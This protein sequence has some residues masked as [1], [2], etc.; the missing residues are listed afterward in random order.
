MTVIGFVAIGIILLVWLA[1]GTI[2]VLESIA[3]EINNGCDSV[4]EA[5]KK[6]KASYDDKSWKVDADLAKIIKDFDPSSAD[7][8]AQIQLPN[9]YFNDSPDSIKNNLAYAIQLALKKRP[10]GKHDLVYSVEECERILPVATQKS[11]RLDWKFIQSSL[12]IPITYPSSPKILKYPQEPKRSGPSYRPLNIVVRLILMNSIKSS[13]KER[14]NKYE[15]DHKLWREVCQKIDEM[16]QFYGQKY[17]IKK[18]EWVRDVDNHEAQMR[19]HLTKLREGYESKDPQYVGMYAELTRLVHD[20]P[21][22]IPF[23]VQA[24]FNA[25]SSVLVADIRLPSIDDI[26][27]IKETRYI[28]SRNS[29]R[30]FKYSDKQLK[31]FYE[32][33]HYALMLENIYAIF[34]SDYKSHIESICLNGRVRQINKATGKWLDAHVLSVQTDRLEFSTID[35]KNVDAKAC[36]QK[37]KG[38]GSPHFAG[39]SAIQPII[40]L[41]KSDKR[42]VDSYNVVDGVADEENIA[43]MP[44]EDFENLIRELFEREFNNGGGEVKVTRASKDGGV[45]AVIFDPDPIRGGKIIIQAKRYTNSV[46]VSAVRDLYGT[47]IN[48]GANKGIM[49]TT[50][51]YG[52]DSYMFAKDKPITLLNGSNLM[53]LLEKHGKKARIDLDEAKRMFENLGEASQLK[54]RKRE[55]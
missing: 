1:S 2:S 49:I 38:I 40:N 21:S 22:W 13:N 17:K 39:I 4:T 27:I 7:Y 26:P 14:R 47:V 5:I 18:S 20:Y 51:D 3:R 55:Q 9:I 43:A 41:N 6:V 24:E 34:E 28:K 10:P 32:Q 37:L 30:D 25:V 23:E 11:C 12:N 35:L 42:F 52:S 31:C 46:N 33:I 50:S 48:E 53:S 15:N 54:I 29:T 16:N 36:F 8:S 45:D 44:W 19:A